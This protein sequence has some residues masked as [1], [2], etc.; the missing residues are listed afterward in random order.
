MGKGAVRGGFLLP[1]GV[2]LPIF[3]S[4]GELRRPTGGH[5]GL[6]HWDPGGAASLSVSE[7]ADGIEGSWLGSGSS[8]V[9]PGVQGVLGGR[10]EGGVLG[11]SQH[12]CVSL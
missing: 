4:L 6:P 12:H 3:R 2:L 11:K 9:Q 1:Q 5:L 8:H 7:V 10:M